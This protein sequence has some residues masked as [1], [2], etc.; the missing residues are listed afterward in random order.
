MNREE[1]IQNIA[2]WN[3]FQVNAGIFF[4]QKHLAEKLVEVFE[5][6]IEGDI[7][8]LGCFVGES[9]K[10]IQK[11]VDLCRVDKKLYV[12]DSFQGLPQPNP[13]KGD[14]FEE[15]SLATNKEVLIKNFENN[16]LRVPVIWEGWFKDIPQDALPEK[17]CFAFLD[18]DLY[19]SI[20][21]SLSKVYHRVSPGGIIA[22]HDYSTPGL[23][24]VKNSVNDFFG[25]NVPDL[26]VIYERDK[27]HDI[28]FMRKK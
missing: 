11:A 28:A 24:G 18:G 26:E 6:N 5:N 14:C 12:Y 23:D 8:E 21:D 2:V 19:E 1:L 15:G 7:V 16:E 4:D 20:Y 25:P 17:I 9:S 27:G 13:E 22:I 10:I 3:N